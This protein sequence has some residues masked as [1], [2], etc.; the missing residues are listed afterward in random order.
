MTLTPPDVGKR[1]DTQPFLPHRLPF[2][3]RLEKI[4]ETTEPCIISLNNG[5][6]P[7]VPIALRQSLPGAG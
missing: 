4:D 1:K 2:P 7:N 3:P 6:S 5:S